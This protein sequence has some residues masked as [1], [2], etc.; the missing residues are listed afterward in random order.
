VVGPF[1]TAASPTLAE[2][3]LA[4]LLA[5]SCPGGP[6]NP[7]RRREKV[8]KPARQC[9][10]AWAQNSLAALSP[11]RNIISDVML[12]NRHE[13]TVR[14]VICT[15]H[16]ATARMVGLES[17]SG[18]RSSRLLPPHGRRKTLGRGHRGRLGFVEPRRPPTVRRVGP[19]TGSEWGRLMFRVGLAGLPASLPRMRASSADLRRPSERSRSATRP[20]SS[21]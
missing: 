9:R 17:D 13:K 11:W 1:R 6:R 5:P 20:A 19:W 21:G 14:E 10:I 7:G 18:K 4:G 12:P 15:A 2:D 16:E 3:D 8:T